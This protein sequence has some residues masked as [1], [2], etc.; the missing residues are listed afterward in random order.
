MAE[1]LTKNE[2]QSQTTIFSEA[3]LSYGKYLQFVQ[4]Q[5]PDK[6]YFI[7][8]TQKDDGKRVVIL[9]TEGDAK[10][11]KTSYNHLSEINVKPGEYFYGGE[12]ISKSGGTPGT[13]GAGTSGG[14][15]L[16]FEVYQPGVDMYKN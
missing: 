9:H 10:G 4:Q 3:G 16:H 13:F 12:Q 8:Q 11:Y 2:Y 14:A 15:H 6:I 1:I 7:W 5:N